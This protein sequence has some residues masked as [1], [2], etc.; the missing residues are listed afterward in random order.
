MPVAAV[1]VEGDVDDQAPP[2][3]FVDERLQ[4]GQLDLVERA[5]RPHEP[6]RR[7]L[8]RLVPGGHHPQAVHPVGLEVAEVLDQEI[9]R[10]GAVEPVEVRGHDQKRRLAVD[11]EMI[12]VHRDVV[13]VGVARHSAAA[14]AAASS[15]ASAAT[16]PLRLNP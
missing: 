14:G 2:A 11:P 3:R 8:V 9:A 15:A 13:A 5:V 4:I 16:T 7:S 1:E 6:N 12:A 10:A